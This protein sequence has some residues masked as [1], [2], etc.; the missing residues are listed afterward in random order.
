MPPFSITFLFLFFLKKKQ[1]L[2]E[3]NFTVKKDTSGNIDSIRVNILWFACK[4]KIK[5]SKVNKLEFGGK[6]NKK[7]NG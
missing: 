1:D 7:L 6:L 5:L 4:L 2:N 3:H